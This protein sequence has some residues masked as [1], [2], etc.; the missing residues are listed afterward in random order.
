MLCCWV[1]GE[2]WVKFQAQVYEGVGFFEVCLSGRAREGKSRGP[3]NGE[4]GWIARGTCSLIEDHYLSLVGIDLHATTFAP[5]LARI[6]H[7]LQLLCAGGNQDQV[8]YI[9]YCSY[10]VQV[11]HGGDFREVQLWEFHSEF[12]NQ[13]CSKDSEE[14]WREAAA[15]WEA[16]AN[17][18]FAAGRYE[19]V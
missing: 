5:V 16:S 8:V 6:N 2:H 12:I 7:I 10:P 19:G 9:E 11:V 4:G 15:F 14:C 13:F 17:G 18:L 3:S 1:H